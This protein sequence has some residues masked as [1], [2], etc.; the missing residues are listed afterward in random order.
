MQ[1]CRLVVKNLRRKSAHA[2]T[3]S[4][5]DHHK[6]VAV[7]LDEMHIRADLVYDKSSGDFI[8]FCNMGDINNY[9]LEVERSVAE[10][11][12]KSDIANS[13]LV[14]MVRDLF[15]PLEFP[16]AQFAIKDLTGELI[17]D[18][19]WN[20]VFHLEM[21]GLKVI[22]A[23]ADG[24]SPFFKMN[25]PA[26]CKV[27]PKQSITKSAPSSSTSASSSSSPLPSSSTSSL[28]STSLASVSASSSA[29]LSAFDYQCKHPFASEDRYIYFFSDSP[30]LLKTIRNCMASSNRHL[31]VSN[32][33]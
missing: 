8:G 30:H 1:V 15:T 17:F 20:V 22:S 4:C 33:N 21:M 32:N 23:T 7:I 19:F 31:W 25:L 24:A 9:L 12:T 13:M 5:P 18:P 14:F 26:T 27:P 28:G 16:Y 2:P 11:S 6:Y 29:I 3:F 10:D